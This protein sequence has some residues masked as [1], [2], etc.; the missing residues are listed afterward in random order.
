[1]F[2]RAFAVFRLHTLFALSLTLLIVSPLTIFVI[3][4]LLQKRGKLYLFSRKTSP[5]TAL[6]EPIPLYGWRGLTRFPIAVVVASGAVIGLAFLVTK[7]NPL[8]IYSSQYAVWSMMLSAWFVL[9]WSILRGAD[10]M[11]PSA[12]QRGYAWLWLFVGSW[13]VMVGVTVS[14]DRLR[15]AGGYFLF[16]YSSAVF[17]ATAITLVEYFALPTAPEYASHVGRDQARHIDSPSTQRSGSRSA[18]SLLT[19]SAQPAEENPTGSDGHHDEE[20]IIPSET[21]PLFR[22]ERRTT[23]ANYTR[24]FRRASSGEDDTNED[25][26]ETNAMTMIMGAYGDE[27]RWSGKLPKWT[28]LLQFMLVAPIVIIL[29]GQVGWV[30]KLA[31]GYPFSPKS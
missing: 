17:L 22:G 1:V 2:G 26:D 4:F 16:F 6:D 9:A 25:E 5:E 13:A 15:I 30:K 12:L 19:A 28:W 23:F 21:T 29:V 3:A 8:I 14:E 18:S 11:R 10:D 7:V 24:S 20:E 27:Q 31:A